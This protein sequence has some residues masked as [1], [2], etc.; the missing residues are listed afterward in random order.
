[1]PGKIDPIPNQVFVGLP[2][3]N[4]KRKY[5]HAITWLPEIPAGP[6]GVIVGL[7]VG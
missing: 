1:M 2:W 6:V 4:V 5:E 3:K 7:I